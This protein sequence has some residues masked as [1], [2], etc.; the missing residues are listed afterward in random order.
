MRQ[1]AAATHGQLTH[2]IV[3]QTMTYPDGAQGAEIHRRV[4]I[5]LI[6][7]QK[8]EPYRINKRVKLNRQQYE[9]SQEK[10]HTSNT[11]I[12]TNKGPW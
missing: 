12:H 11:Y 7:Q 6:P 3:Q 2:T 5:Q 1:L 9:R 8:I 10:L 4:L